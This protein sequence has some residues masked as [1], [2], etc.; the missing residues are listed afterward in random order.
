MTLCLL[1]ARPY[2]GTVVDKTLM[3]PNKNKHDID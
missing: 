3:S 2:F 1:C